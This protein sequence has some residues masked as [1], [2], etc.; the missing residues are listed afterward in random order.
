MLT[1]RYDVRNKRKEFEVCR[2]R[3][4]TGCKLMY[5]SGNNVH[6]HTTDSTTFLTP[7]VR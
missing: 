1:I 2:L 4:Y 7:I 5:Y 6:T 3:D